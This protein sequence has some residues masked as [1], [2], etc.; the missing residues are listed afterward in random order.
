[1]EPE[2]ALTVEKMID[3]TL[4]VRIELKEVSL[5]LLRRALW[6]SFEEFIKVKGCRRATYVNEEPRYIEVV[7]TYDR[8]HV[9][10]LIEAEFRHPLDHVDNIMWIPKHWAE[11]YNAALEYATEDGVTL[12]LARTTIVVDHKA[13]MCWQYID[14]RPNTVELIAKEILPLLEQ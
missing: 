1:M 6:A 10:P 9:I 2:V 14:I 5:E 13:N 11:M 8:L 7:E 4:V 3:N 12:I